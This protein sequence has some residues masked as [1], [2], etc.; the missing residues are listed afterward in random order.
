MVKMN[1]NHV[2]ISLLSER[3]LTKKTTQLSFY[4]LACAENWHLQA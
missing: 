3:E 1:L 2:Y 4:C